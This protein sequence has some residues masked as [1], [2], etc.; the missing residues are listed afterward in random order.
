MYRGILLLTIL[1]SIAY[2]C[3]E[4]W[5][6]RNSNCSHV[7]Y[8]PRYTSMADPKD[9]SSW[10]EEVAR[11]IVAIPHEEAL[12]FSCL[13]R[14]LKLRHVGQHVGTASSTI[15][16]T[17]ISKGKEPPLYTEVDISE[18]FEASRAHPQQQPAAH[19]DTYMHCRLVSVYICI[20]HAAK[21]HP[22]STQWLAWADRSASAASASTTFDWSFS[23]PRPSSWYSGAARCSEDS[24]LLS[25]EALE[26][27]SKTS[28]IRFSSI[29]NLLWTQL[30]GVESTLE[31]PHFLCVPR[32]SEY[33]TSAPLSR[34][35]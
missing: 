30:L 18:P 13:S 14:G 12:C 25:F 8:R 24:W 32:S 1:L 33:M 26:A 31:F 17:R 23:L 10:T 19:R 16:Y 29:A 34:F 3:I 22:K 35:V 20:P 27:S 9:F 28:W 7:L 15:S 2:I 21:R 6:L 5:V 11:L 4:L